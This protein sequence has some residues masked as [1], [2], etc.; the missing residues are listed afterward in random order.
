VSLTGE[1]R[2]GG[3]LTVVNAIPTGHGAAIG[4]DLETRASVDLTREPGP[5]EVAIAGESDADPSLAQACLRVVGRAHDVELSGTVETT[6]DIPIARG[7]KSS[8][9]AANAIVLATLDALDVQPTPEHVLELSLAG[10]REAGVTVTGALDDAAASLL[11]GLVVTDNTR[12]EIRRRKRLDASR[13]VLLLVPEHRQ[14]TS[15]AGDLDDAAPVAE[16]AH[17]L[18]AD[19]DWHAA[20]T[21]NGL[22]VAAALGAPLDP[23]YRALAAGARAA[24]LTGTGPATGAVCTEATTNA[25][26]SAWQ[27][28]QAG[29]ITAQTRNEEVIASA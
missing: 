10:A 5:V 16:E 28:Y 2:S 1:G 14:R 27:P 12:D 13:P 25:V 15:D 8:S 29:I 18:L 6:S 19:D 22:G 3:A 26:R 9:A 7:L 21:V 11:G 17:D 23:A 4:L 20:L 24:G